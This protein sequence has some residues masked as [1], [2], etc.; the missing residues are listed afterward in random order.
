[1]C[2]CNDRRDAGLKIVV[3]ATRTS[4]R[5][6]VDRCG[7]RLYEGLRSSAGGSAGS[8]NVIHEQD[9]LTADDGWIG[10]L[11]RAT[12]VVATLARR[13]ARLA[14]GGTKAHERAGSKSEMRCGMRFAQ[15]V[16]GAFSKNARLVESAV[17]VFAAMK[18]HGNDK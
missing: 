12:D 18:R 10:N 7:S 8:E 14:A 15:R 2:S 9:T 5:R 3:D 16:N 4:E 1:M 6:D 11:E 17:P 13:E